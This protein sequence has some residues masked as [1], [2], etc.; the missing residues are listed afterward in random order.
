MGMVMLG[1]A[2]NGD[3]SVTEMLASAKDTTHEKI[4]LAA[5]RATVASAL[6]ELTLATDVIPTVSGRPVPIAPFANE[7]YSSDV[8]STIER[9]VGTSVPSKLNIT[10]GRDATSVTRYS[11]ESEPSPTQTRHTPP[12]TIK[13]IRSGYLYDCDDGWISE[14]YDVAG[15]GDDA[16]REHV[17][18]KGIAAE[19]DMRCVRLDGIDSISASLSTTMSFLLCSVGMF[20]SLIL[21]ASGC[22]SNV[23]SIMGKTKKPLAMTGRVG[24]LGKCLFGLSI[25]ASLVAAKE[26]SSQR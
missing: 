17:R 7:N 5:G 23:G 19:G 16:R 20:A 26:E 9:G 6:S 13:S 12:E 2:G 3:D 14:D 21:R 8:S 11:D 22:M 25:L 10:V 15:F 1:G 4:L 18:Q 24:R